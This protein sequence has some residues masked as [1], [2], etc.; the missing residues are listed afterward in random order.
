MM[1]RDENE[2]TLRDAGQMV[3]ILLVTL[4]LCF[5]FAGRQLGDV[6]GAVIDQHFAVEDAQRAAHQNRLVSE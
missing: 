4:A 6:M 5:F 2:L 1:R 3:V